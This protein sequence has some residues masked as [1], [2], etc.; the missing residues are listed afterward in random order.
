MSSISVCLCVCVHRFSDLVIWED[1]LVLVRT[2][3]LGERGNSDA[4]KSF[5]HPMVVDLSVS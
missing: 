5:V 3:K 2:R 4:G 1:G